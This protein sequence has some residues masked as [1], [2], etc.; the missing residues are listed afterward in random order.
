MSLYGFILTTGLALAG[1]DDASTPESTEQADGGTLNGGGGKGGGKKGKKNGGKKGKKTEE[2]SS[3]MPFM[4]PWGRSSVVVS[5]GLGYAYGLARESEETGAEDGEDGGSQSSTCIQGNCTTADSDT[6]AA[7]GWGRH[8][9]L[10]VMFPGVTSKSRAIGPTLSYSRHTLQLTGLKNQ[11][12]VDPNDGNIAT[13]FVQDRAD[14][15]LALQHAELGFT[16]S[17]KVAPRN[18]FFMQFSLDAGY[19]WGT[20]ETTLRSAPDTVVTGD[21]RGPSIG[22]DFGIGF[23]FSKRAHLL[24]TPFTHVDWMMLHPTNDDTYP[25]LNDGK[26]MTTTV[27]VK[28]ELMAAF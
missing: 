9:Q 26:A 17:T 12:V 7:S 21:I 1:V 24:V 20:V 11:R 2:P 18:P 14:Y 15:S 23:S 28:V 22:V 6:N 5:A 13:P 19:A 4:A 27:P 3:A 8:S 16:F 10:S 25:F